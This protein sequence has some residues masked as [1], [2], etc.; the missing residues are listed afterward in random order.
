M[1]FVKAPWWLKKLYSSFVWKIRTKEKVLYLTFDDGPHETATPFVLDELKKY[2][3]KATF[4]CI[5][6]NVA[7]LPSVY[8]RILDEG[9]A[10]GNHTY[11]HL[12]GWKT[13]DT[14]YINNI[15]DAAEL[16]KS[17]LFRPPY[18]RIKK[19]QSKLLM[20]KE[21]AA[22]PLFKIIMWDVLSGDFDVQLSPQQCLN[23]VLKHTQKG[24]IIVF[25]DSTKA[26]SRMSYALPNVLAHFS[27]E[28]YVF[29]AL[30]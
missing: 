22:R 14:T 5:G 26:W 3:A 1:Y 13:D 29:K 19:F 11:N 30:E 7:S 23:N 8:K 28:G 6:K 10:T 15:I 25:H 2:G 4:F 18:G 20:R 24:S 16:I 17:N 27:K 9:H 12:N 21:D